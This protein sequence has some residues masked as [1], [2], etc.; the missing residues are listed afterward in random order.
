VVSGPGKN[1]P[2]IGSQLWVVSGPG[3]RHPWLRVKL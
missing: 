1:H 3:K 2:F